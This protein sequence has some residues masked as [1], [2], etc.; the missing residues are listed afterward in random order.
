MVRCRILSLLASFLHL[1]V[2]CD[3]DDYQSQV[4]TTCIQSTCTY[5]SDSMSIQVGKGCGGTLPFGRG[6]GFAAM[7]SLSSLSF[8]DNMS[9]FA[10][11][12]KFEGTENDLVHWLESCCGLDEGKGLHDVTQC[13]AM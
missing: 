3:D 4:V 12:R 10:S 6:C 9:C 7:L 13:N 5:L 2:A 11:N 1:G 8:L